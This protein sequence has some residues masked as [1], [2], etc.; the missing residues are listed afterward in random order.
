MQLKQG[1]EMKRTILADVDGF[2]PIIDDLA[3]E[4]GLMRAAVFGRMWRFCQMS[5]NVCRAS[6]ETI[7]DGLGIDKAT[8]MRHAQELVNDG[9]LKDLTPEKRNS[10]HVY[11]DTGKAGVRISVGVAHSNTSKT[12][13]ECNATVAESQLKIVSKK[14]SKTHGARK[15][16]APRA[17]TPLQQEQQKLE[18]LFSELS[19]RPIPPG[20]A[21]VIWH[22]TTA[23]WMKAANGQS[24]SVMRAA[25]AAH[26]HD[27][28]SVK[29]PQSIDYKFWEL[30][31]PAPK[32]ESRE[33]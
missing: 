11:Q 17:L 9:Y 21:A 8:V 27:G 29:G 3:K 6:L 15:E 32:H 13:A 18:S 20:K 24:E 2:T 23:A 10:P 7:A 31:N 19:G 12:V 33:L 1:G 22:I 5:D 16:R 26:T 28:L 30:L 25:Y 4:Y 14:D